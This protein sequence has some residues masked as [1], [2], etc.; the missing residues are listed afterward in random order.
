MLSQL[1][2]KKSLQLPL[3]GVLGSVTPECLLFPSLSVPDAKRQ[4]A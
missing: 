1:G 4:V 2:D 3:R